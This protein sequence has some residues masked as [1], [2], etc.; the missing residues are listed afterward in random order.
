M[1][2]LFFSDNAG[3]QMA[4]EL[5]RDLTRIGR[6]GDNDVVSLDLRMSR[7]HAV[8]AR[9]ADGWRIR[10]AGSSLGVYV[11]SVR[12]EEAVLR[13]GD[14][15]RLGDSLYTFV[16]Q[17]PSSVDSVEVPHEAGAAVVGNALLSGVQEAA[18]ALR[19]VVRGGAG[20]VSA[21]AARPG[22]RPADEVLD[23]METSLEAL[24]A[25]LSRIERARRTL[26]T[27][28]E[29]GRVLNSAVDRGNLLDLTMDLALRVLRA[30]RGFLMLKKGTGPGLSLKVVRNMG[31]EVGN[32]TTPT[33]AAGIARQVAAS[34]QPVLTSDALTD[35][36]FADHRSVVDFK[37]RS[38]VCVPLRD[39]AGGVMGVIYV[40]NRSEGLGF[41]EDDRDFLSAFA[42]YAAIAIENQRL[43]SDAA[44]RARAEEELR[45]MRRL[46]EMKSELMSMVA[47]DVRTPLTSIRSYA[48]ILSD[49]FE[50]IPPDQRRV[51]LERIVRQAERLDRL[52][53]NYLDLERIEAGALPIRIEE[54]G[55]AG[56]V[57]ETC[58]GFEGL[59]AEQKVALRCAAEE[60]TGSIRADRDRLLQVLANLV[61]NALKFTPEGGRVVVGCRPAGLPGG[62]AAVLFDVTDTG[63]G[64]APED[65][66][67]LFRKF[68]QIGR[69]PGGRPRGT[70]LG[71]VLAREIVELHGGR[72][73][74]ESTPGRGSRFY[75]AVPVEGPEPSSGGS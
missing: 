36:R 9:T 14:T 39:R 27:L 10:D 47:H 57:R 43:L 66:D 71:L 19:T 29:I 35:K 37:I 2:C 75:F 34:G 21:P 40:D 8:L 51:F 53:S 58:E 56:L 18:R 38:L 48:E 24:R 44:A 73:G 17:P 26:Q 54:V 1:A 5:A 25:G 74:A 15:I 63:G 28:Y 67:R 55:A 46:D 31:E 23:R 49:D 16:D 42:N 52:T 50:E 33:I 7:H 61:S 59:A 13:D 45:A 22:D 11:N 6:A 20:P 70:G 3:R 12:V 4:H 69:A 30:E 32:E 62:R 64:I 60:G 68:S 72:I 41:D 65:M